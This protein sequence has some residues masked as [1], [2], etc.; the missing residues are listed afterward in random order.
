MS[1][2]EAKQFV[3]HFVNGD[4]TP[5][6]YATFLQWLRGASLEELNEIADAHE[7]LHESWSLPASEP[8]P[9]WVAMLEGKLDELGQE[10]DET[11]RT[12]GEVPVRHI[13]GRGVFRRRVWV[14]AA[15]V[16]VLLLAGAI[17]YTQRS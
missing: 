4:Y 9:E 7:G 2:Q 10:A 16:V 17:L 15:S 14:A 11:D 8:S 1:L 6:E 12:M 13:G 3:A 5:E